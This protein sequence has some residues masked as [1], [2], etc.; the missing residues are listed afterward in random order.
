[1]LKEAN[2]F[3]WAI[4]S[5]V[6]LDDLISAG[7]IGV[8]VAKAKFDE[9]R[10]KAF[11]TVATWWVTH[12]IRRTAEAGAS[13]RVPP[14]VRKAAHQAGAQI[15]FHP[16]PLAKDLIDAAWRPGI[17]EDRID[18]ENQMHELVGKLGLLS[19]IERKVILLVFYHEWTLKQVG[20]SLELSASKT[21]EVYRG[22]LALLREELG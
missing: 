2:R 19:T 17:T 18:S 5:V 13:V 8:E 6:S 1:M 4:G 7:H 22:A 12:F 15:A 3:R 16:Q 21:R 9:T 14:S 11:S 20:E 10:G